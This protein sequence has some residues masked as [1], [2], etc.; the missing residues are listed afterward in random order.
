LL[1]EEL[2]ERAK[3]KEEK[4]AKKRQRLADD[5]TNLLY[6]FKVDEDSSSDLIHISQYLAK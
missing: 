2:V 1:F 4:E 6:S 5:F 3:E